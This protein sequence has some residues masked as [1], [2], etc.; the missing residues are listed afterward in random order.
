MPLPNCL[1][2]VV[3]HQF[4]QDIHIQGFPGGSDGKVSSC[5]VGDLGSITGLEESPGG[6]HGNLLQRSCL[7]NPHGQR[8]LAAYSLWGRVAKSQ[9]RLN[10]KAHP[11]LRVLLIQNNSDLFLPLSF[12]FFYICSLFFQ[13]CCYCYHCYHYD[14]T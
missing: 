11:C 3:F 5:S 4:L 14:S 12:L 2:I 10:N 6:E 1:F 9:T 8:S 7:E 13:C